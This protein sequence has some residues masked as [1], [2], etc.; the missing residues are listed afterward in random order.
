MVGDLTGMSGNSMVVVYS[1]K[2]NRFVLAGSGGFA[3]RYSSN[4][5]TWVSGVTG[6]TT[7]SMC[8]SPELGIFCA[9]PLT[10]T[11]IR[12][13]PDGI[14]WTTR[15]GISMIGTSICWAAEL[16]IF[17]AVGGNVIQTSPDGITWTSRTPPDSRTYSQV[18][19][20]A[21]L[22]LFI[23]VT[24]QNLPNRITTSPDGINWTIRN[25]PTLQ[26]S[27]VAYSPYLNLAVAIFAAG[28]VITNYL[29]STDGINWTLQTTLPGVISWRRMIWV[30][31]LYAFVICGDNNAAY[32]FDG[33]NWTTVTLP[34][35]SLAIT[36]DFSDSSLVI[37]PN[38]SSQNPVYTLPQPLLAQ[39]GVPTPFNL[40]GTGTGTIGTSGQYAIVN[41]GATGLTYTTG[42]GSGGVSQVG[43]AGNSSF[44]NRK[45][46]N[47]FV[48]HNHIQFKQPNHCCRNIHSFNERFPNNHRDVS[49]DQRVKCYKYRTVC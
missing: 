1:P 32:S 39:N 11:S 34:S 42:P 25:T 5:N 48:P 44:N 31:W 20:V 17:C 28:G 49:G 36:M 15:T 21:K 22:G 7:T 8:W 46:G 6:V 33:L 26:L 29:T 9:T 40:G 47:E 4:G 23:T 30:P 12:T 45:R 19:W 37:I 27:A 43:L 10:G 18:I 3:A 13:S 38:N 2:L 14:T 41:A 24:N 35:G 16:G